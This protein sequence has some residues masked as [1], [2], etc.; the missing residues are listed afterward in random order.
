MTAVAMDAAADMVAMLRPRMRGWLH[1]GLTPVVVV[2]GLLLVAL[3]DTGPERTAT[4]VF[5]GSSLLL[6]AVSALYNLHPWDG[7]LGVWLQRFDHANIYVLIAGSYTPFAVLLLKGAAVV[8][9]LVLAWAGAIVGAAFRLGFPTAPR[10]ATTGSYLVLGWVA[11]GFTPQLMGAGNPLA[12]VLLAAGGVFY[13]VGAVVYAIRRPDPWPTW[14]G[15]HEVFHGF[16][17]VGFAAHCAGVFLLHT[18]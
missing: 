13:S 1:A 8:I 17:A 18:S 15:F 14:F 11:I 12:L 5:A 10:W 4:A 7:S 2:A 6:F 3:A 9:M 16:T